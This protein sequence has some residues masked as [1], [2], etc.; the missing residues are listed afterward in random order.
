MIA[1]N[2]HARRDWGMPASIAGAAPTV[3]VYA[4]GFVEAQVRSDDP[5][6]DLTVAT[7]AAARPDH[8]ETFNKK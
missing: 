7:A 8:C 6:F 4:V 1:G 5:R 2:G 3:G